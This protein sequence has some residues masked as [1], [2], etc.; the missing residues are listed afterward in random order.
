MRVF[1]VF[2][3]VLSVL[4]GFLCVMFVCLWS[5]IW[6]GGFAWDGSF[7]QFNWHPVLM[8]TSLVVLYGNGERKQFCFC[9]ACINTF[10]LFFLIE[11]TSSLSFS[12]LQS[13]SITNTHIGKNQKLF[14]L[15]S[16][17]FTFKTEVRW[18]VK[19]IEIFLLKIVHNPPFK[20]KNLS[21]FT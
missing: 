3:Y 18:N 11:R 6:R 17:L 13:F 10:S 21:S 12:C 1:P 9:L 19:Q 8:V 15:I 5:G 20:K 7:L 2:F 4:L 16:H 14:L